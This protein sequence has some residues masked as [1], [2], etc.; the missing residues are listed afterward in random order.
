APGEMVKTVR[1]SLLGG[2]TAEAAES[3]QLVLSSPS[4]NATIV[5][6][7]ALATIIDN[8]APSGTPV[9]SI[10]DA[11]VDEVD[12]TATVTVILNKP[13]TS[14]VTFDVAGQNVTAGNNSD[15]RNLQ[16]GKIAFAPGETAKTVIFGLLNDTRIE[17]TELFDVVLT[18]PVGATLGDARAHAII[19]G[20]DNAAVA[21]PVLH[22]ANVV[23][24]EDKGYI[25]F[26]VTLAAPSSAGASINYS[27][28]AGTAI[29][30]S[31]YI[32][33]TGTLAF[34][35]GEV[36]KTIRVTLIDDA[37]AEASLENFTLNL[38]GAVNATIGT[39]SA[40][41]TIIDNE[42][43]APGA[44][45]A[46]AGTPGND[47]LQGTQFSD[48]M[49]GAAGNDTFNGGEGN[50]SM[51]GSGGND[52][53]IVEN[54][55]DTYTEGAGG[56][57]DQVIS[58]LATHT[59]SSNVEGLQLAGT[60]T[61][62]VG[63]N[64]ANTITG[65]SKNNTIDG[66]SGNDILNG[67]TGSDNITGGAGVDFFVFSSAL[68]AVTNVDSVADF[69]VVDDTIRLENGIFTLFTATGA[70]SVDTFVSGPG[71]I[72]LDSNDFLIYDNASGNLY[73]DIDGNGANAHVVFATLTG[74]PV[75]TAADFVI[76]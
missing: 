16:I 29:F 72:A 74:I 67:A 65:N 23:A 47:I 37:S 5:D 59:L 76:I 1:V 35:P 49:T 22:L 69:S 73:Y 8:D 48:A 50:D 60:A 33:T 58:Y 36:S 45:I 61:A 63:N 13:S 15:F 3:F 70:I 2:T 56:G 19:A 40:T 55:G 39:A 17:G 51:T 54:A 28:S 31:D 9:A 46:L 6:G 66:G 42:S 25:D 52:I 7:S 4:A 38:S 24:S 18:N 57:N 21:S 41:A 20:N 43:A 32:H 11:I 34:I 10:T 64:L 26:L 71:A 62:G 44:P 27:T 75:L 68:N 14:G 53:Y 12:Q 30:N